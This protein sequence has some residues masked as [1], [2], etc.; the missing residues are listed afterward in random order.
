VTGSNIGIGLE[1]ARV[2]LINGGTV[3]MA[4]RNTKRAE[5]ALNALKKQHAEL[6]LKAHI[7]PLDLS[8]FESVREFSRLYKEKFDKLDVLINNAG[9]MMCP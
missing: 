6:D 4:N 8:S 1:T 2:L 5:D 9:V 7:M 3:I